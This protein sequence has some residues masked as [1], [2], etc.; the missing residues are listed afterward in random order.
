MLGCFRRDGPSEKATVSK[1]I[2]AALLVIDEAHERSDS[3]WENSTLANVVDRRYDAERATIL[4]SNLTKAAFAQA[5]G[6][7]IVSRIHEA[8]ET[9]VCDWGSFRQ[10]G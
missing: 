2:D 4:V 9:V 6:P 1:L 7:S 10:P 5:I 8:G 3:A